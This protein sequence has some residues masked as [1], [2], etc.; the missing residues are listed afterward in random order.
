MDITDNVNNIVQGIVAQIT[1]QVQQQAMT[2]IQQ[3]IN[4]V[5]ASIDSTSM[6]STILSQKIDEALGR[7]PINASKI[8]SQLLAQVNTLTTSLAQT[9]QTQA[10][11]AAKESVNT[12]LSRID[13]SQLC[14]ATLLAAIQQQ[15]LKFAPASIPGSAIDQSTINLSGNSITG[16]IIKHFGS[17]GIDDKANSC[18]LSIFDE[19]TVVENN[20]VTKSLTVKGATTIEGD[21]NVTGTMPSSSPLFQNLVSASSHAVKSDQ[22]LLQN[23]ADSV[24]TQLK[25]AGIDLNKITL[26]G[27]DVIVG[28]TIGPSV[29]Q[30]NLQKV[31]QLQELQVAGESFLS[32]TLYTTNNRVG[33]NTIEPSCALSVWDQE[34]EVT[35][36]KQ[37]TN[38]A[39]I[40]TPRNQSLV[41]SSNGQ[42]NITLTPDG[43]TTVNKINMGT[44]SFT[45]GGIPPMDNQPKGSIVFNSNPSLGGP[46]GWVSLGE[47][48]WANFGIID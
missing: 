9:V 29:T 25:S 38:T 39:I 28:N 5:V 37:T 2:A 40:E 8:E 44:M 20:L 35:V 10:I 12:Q 42:N 21:L 45:V 46:L 3:T 18:Q 14:Q 41:L 47:A 1:A 27:Q 15:T 30:S 6:M 33:I 13:F 26:Q 43:A 24:I 7:L 31:G 36:S 16:G 32:A 4:N 48:R 11:A 19:V 34:V 23:F 22:S 17:T